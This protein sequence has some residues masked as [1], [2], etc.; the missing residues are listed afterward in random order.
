MVYSVKMFMIFEKKGRTLMEVS[1]WVVW[2]QV[3]LHK[4]AFLVNSVICFQPGPK[5]P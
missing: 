3:Y 4:L 2:Q 1:M 5:G